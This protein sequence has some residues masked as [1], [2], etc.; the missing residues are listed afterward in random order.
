MPNN[1]YFD[2]K[3]DKHLI[4]SGSHFWCHGHLTAQ[5]V[6]ELSPDPRY[7]TGCFDFLQK[8][9]EPSLKSTQSLVQ[10]S[11]DKDRGCNTQQTIPNQVVEP[12]TDDVT[13]KIMVLASAGWSTRRIAEE[14]NISH[15]TVHRRLKALQGV[16]I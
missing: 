7:C 12:V 1:G 8:G 6:S 13:A 10:A 3:R 4:A 9:L 11:L 15:M 16:L 5:P 14:F 2:N